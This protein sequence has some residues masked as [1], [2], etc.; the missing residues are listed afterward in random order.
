[1]CV[2]LREDPGLVLVPPI[3]VVAKIEKQL[4]PS[5]STKRAALENVM[6]LEV[7]NMNGQS[8]AEIEEKKREDALKLRTLQGLPSRLKQILSDKCSRRKK[9]ALDALLGILGYNS[10][11]NQ[12]GSVIEAAQEL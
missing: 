6:Q 3:V 4:T 2:L 11:L 10:L 7:E 5:L 12:K 1:M 9:T 8:V